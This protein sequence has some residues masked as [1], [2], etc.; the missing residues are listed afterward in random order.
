MHKRIRNK[1]VRNLEEKSLE[2]RLIERCFVKQDNS[3][4]AVFKNT[5]FLIGINANFIELCIP[6]RV[7]IEYRGNEMTDIDQ[8]FR[9][10][11]YL[12]SRK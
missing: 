5:E 3:Y 1:I 7:R 10:I 6:C 9:D 4:R 2:D 12:K 8:I 11:E